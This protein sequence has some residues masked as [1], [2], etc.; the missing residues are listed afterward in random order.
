VSHGDETAEQQ[1]PRRSMAK[2]FRD[3]MAM[4]VEFRGPSDQ[5][6]YTV[7]ASEIEQ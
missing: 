3:E 7:G 6:H 4:L 2:Q 5:R 1:A